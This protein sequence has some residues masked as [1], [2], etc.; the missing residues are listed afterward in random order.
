MNAIPRSVIAAFLSLAG[1][2]F[3]SA[4]PYQPP[5]GTMVPWTDGIL[6]VLD[7]SVAWNGSNDRAYWA[8]YR[9]NVPFRTSA[10][11]EPLAAYIGRPGA[12]YGLNTESESNWHSSFF[13]TFGRWP[14]RQEV[15]D[16]TIATCS[17]PTPPPA[18]RGLA[19]TVRPLKPKPVPPVAPPVVPP[20]S[21]P[22]PPAIPECPSAA[23]TEG[24]EPQS[25]VTPVVG[26]W[27]Y[28][29]GLQSTGRLSL[30]LAEPCRVKGKP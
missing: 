18:C 17:S 26:G 5:P 4:A 10:T 11:G 1:F 3:T 14:S 12:P 23:D 25:V 9:G 6:V 24:A 7:T 19:A 29:P 28:R 21:S 2:A 22:T 27:Y 13:D 30:R 20:P 8:R 16:W 15:W